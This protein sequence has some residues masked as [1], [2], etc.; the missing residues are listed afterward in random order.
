MFEPRILRE[1]GRLDNV[2][3]DDDGAS[4]NR[5]DDEHVPAHAVEAQ[6]NGGVQANHVHKH[7]LVRLEDG[8]VPGEQALAHLGRLVLVIGVAETGRI[9]DGV[10]GPQQEEDDEDG[11]RGANGRAYREEDRLLLDLLRL[12]AVLWTWFGNGYVPLRRAG[13]R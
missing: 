10:E 13:C 8:L 11:E 2:D 6:E 4:D 1:L 12:A 3:G 9:Y 5:Q 7:V